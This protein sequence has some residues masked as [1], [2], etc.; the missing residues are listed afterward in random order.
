MEKLS[1]LSRLN[2]KVIP[3][4]L[5]ATLSFSSLTGYSQNIAQ[6]KNPAQ[7]SSLE[8][9]T[10][11]TGKEAPMVQPI[12]ISGVLQDN[13]TDTG[14][15]GVIRLYN[16]KDKSFLEETA[17]DANGNFKINF[18][19]KSKISDFLLSAIIASGQNNQPESYIRTIKIPAKNASN[20]AIRAVPYPEFDLDNDGI[21]TEKEK[22]DSIT[23]FRQYAEEINPYFWKWN[24]NELEKKGGFEIINKN[25]T[26]GG[27]GAEFTKEQLDFI[28][29]QILNIEN[30]GIYT[31]G[32][33]IKVQKDNASTPASQRH[34]RIV[35]GGYDENPNWIIVVPMPASWDE[36]AIGGMGYDPDGFKNRGYVYLRINT[37]G[38]YSAG[39][40]AHEF[41]HV[42]IAPG[43][44]Q[45][46]LPPITV[47][48]NGPAE[49]KSPGP[50]DK[51]MADISSETTYSGNF[52]SPSDWDNILG[53]AYPDG[54]MPEV[55]FK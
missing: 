52:N 51:K 41:G 55:D 48:H 26:A 28:E 40:L 18:D 35:D 34:Y 38:N 13:E 44:T 31:E 19:N 16:S 27:A 1:L 10:Q 2:R 23:K 9:R 29:Q 37:F 11:D 25:I 45:A 6:T 42:F 46:L 22:Q 30:I 21:I 36:Y 3:A 39:L 24:L 50:A 53:T 54:K 4:V 17:T 15:Q 5:A 7:A 12:Y 20:L 43:H 32:R 14:K 33:K 8:S 47:M 49:M